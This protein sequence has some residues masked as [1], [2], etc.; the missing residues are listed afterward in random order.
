MND[1][2][3]LV[4]TV[5]AGAAAILVGMVFHKNEHRVKWGYVARMTLTSTLFVLLSFLS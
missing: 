3:I 5:M 4:L 1:T 2:E